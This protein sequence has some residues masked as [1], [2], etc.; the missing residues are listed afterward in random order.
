MHARLAPP[1]Q[2][3]ECEWSDPVLMPRLAAIA[4]AV[5]TEAR[6]DQSVAPGTKLVLAGNGVADPGQ[7]V[8]GEF[9]QLLT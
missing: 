5:G 6:D 3:C 7:V 9:D 2:R 8:A 4:A 1:N